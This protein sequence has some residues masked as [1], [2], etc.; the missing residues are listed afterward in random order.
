MDM[1]FEESGEILH[2]REG[3]HRSPAA[4]DHFAYR[5][6]HYGLGERFHT[7]KLKGC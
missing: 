5:L 6:L 1:F 4:T 3:L 2:V 7:A